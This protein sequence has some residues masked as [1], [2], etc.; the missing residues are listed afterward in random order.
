V[1]VRS[2]PASSSPDAE[3]NEGVENFVLAVPGLGAPDDS[4]DR[5]SLLQKVPNVVPVR[6]DGLNLLVSRTV[7]ALVYANDI[8]T[9]SGSANLSGPTLGRIA[10]K[11]VSVIPV[12]GAAPNVQVEILEGHEVCS[13]GVVPFVEAPDAF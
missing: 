11:V 9:S 2:A 6:A 5:E 10:F 4:G 7:C 12:D 3:S 13:E 8:V 1:A